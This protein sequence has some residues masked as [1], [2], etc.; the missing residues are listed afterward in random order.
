[1]G[2]QRNRRRACSTRSTTPTPQASARFGSRIGSAGDITGDGIRDVIV[3]GIDRRARRRRSGRPRRCMRSRPAP[4]RNAGQAFIFNG[5]TGALVRHARRTR[6]PTW[7]PSE[8]PAP[9]GCGTFGLAVQSPGDTE[10]LTA[11]DD[12]LVDKESYATFGRMYLFQR[13]GPA[14]CCCGSIR[15]EP[16][17]GRQ[18]R[19][20]GRRRPAR[21][22]TSTATA[23]PDLYANGFHN[24]TARRAKARAAHGSSTGVPAA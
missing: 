7:R 17:A 24:T 22:A 12:Q 13:Q 1:M 18:L 3:G 9:Q 14:S 4:G 19:L 21:P 5:A 10:R 23:F 6:P 11:S 20:P 15:P 2:L 16:Q 8:H